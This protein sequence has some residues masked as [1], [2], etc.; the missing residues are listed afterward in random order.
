[1]PKVETRE[2]LLDE[3]HNSVYS[4]HLGFTKMYL[5]LKTKYWWKGM[6]NDVA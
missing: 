5:D 2:F 3:A 1:M 4:I 6:K